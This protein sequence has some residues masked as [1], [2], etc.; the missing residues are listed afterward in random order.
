MIVSKI[1][2]EDIVRN[3]DI[4]HYVDNEAARLSTIKGSS[5]SKE[6]AWLIQAFWESEAVL[7]TQSWLSRVPTECN[8][9]DGPSRDEWEEIMELYPHCVRRDWRL[10][11]EEALMRRWTGRSDTEASARVFREFK[12]GGK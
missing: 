2:W 6:S 5:P 7:R 12:N 4:L 9:G 10:R 8:P 1:L 11:D 3:R